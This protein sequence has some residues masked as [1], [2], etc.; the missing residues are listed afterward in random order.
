MKGNTIFGFEREREML[1][2]YHQTDQ[3]L[4]FLLKLVQNVAFLNDN[5][6]H[7]ISPVSIYNIF[8]DCLDHF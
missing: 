2:D 5:K 4:L 3:T 7:Q 8:H 6:I 1:A